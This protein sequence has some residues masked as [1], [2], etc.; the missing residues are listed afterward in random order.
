MFGTNPGAHQP[1]SSIHPRNSELTKNQFTRTM[2][3]MRYR[4]NGTGRDTYIGMDNGGN[5]HMYS[6][7]G[8]KDP[9]M[10]FLPKLARSPSN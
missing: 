3:D 2:A 10:R 5:N 9:P 1:R 8:N 6:P 7:A 4:T